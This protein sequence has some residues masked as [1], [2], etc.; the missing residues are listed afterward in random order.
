MTKESTIGYTARKSGLFLS[1]VVLVGFWD[2]EK[3]PK[4][5]CICAE[6]TPTAVFK[7]LS[8]LSISLSV[9]LAVY[10]PVFI[11]HFFAAAARGHRRPLMSRYLICASYELLRQNR[12][13]RKE[14]KCSIYM[15]TEGRHRPQ[16][17]KVAP[18]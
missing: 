18:I 15:Y 1:K 10:I 13:Q 2:T 17:L 9:N 8:L 12:R 6:Y 4:R 14:E 11:S 7:L 5:R 3:S 16:K